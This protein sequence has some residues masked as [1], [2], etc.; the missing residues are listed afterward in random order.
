MLSVVPEKEIT[1]PE[2]AP[3]HELDGIGR[4]GVVLHHGHQLLIV[5][6][7]GIQF[8]KRSL[9]NAV[10]EGESWAE[11][12]VKLDGVTKI[13]VVRVHHTGSPTLGLRISDRCMRFE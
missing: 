7:L 3:G 8:P 6:P 5:R 1:L 12:A 13:I 11:M 10:S 9:G 4:A 2:G